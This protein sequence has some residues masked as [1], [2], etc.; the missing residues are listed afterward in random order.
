MEQILRLTKMGHKVLLLLLG[1]WIG[2]SGYE[3]EMKETMVV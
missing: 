3:P 1:I 2:A